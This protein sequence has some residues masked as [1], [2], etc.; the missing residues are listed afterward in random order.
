MISQVQPAPN[1]AVVLCTHN[2][3]QWIDEQIQSLL[4]QTHPVAIRVFDDA[5][6]DATVALVREYPEI[7]NIKCVVRSKS[8]GV[9]ENFSRGI[10]SVLD[11]G[12]TYIALA[13]QDDIWLPERIETGLAALQEAEEDTPAFS[14]HLVHSDLAMVNA[15]NQLIHK[16]FM[17][18]RQYQ[19]KPTNSL[20]TILG[21]NGVMGNTILM[22]H[23]LASLALPFPNNLHVHDYWLAL[24]AE[25]LGDRHY[26]DQALVRY[27]I[28]DKNVS[29]SA[30]TVTFGPKRWF[31]GLSFHGL[32]QRDFKL[33]FKED[34]RQNAVRLLLK[35]ERFN[36]LCADDQATITAFLNYLNFQDSR[37]KILVSVLNNRFLRPGLRHRLRVY[38]SILTSQRY[39]SVKQSHH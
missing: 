30:N 3:A 7:Q 22:N 25:L 34:S 12:F 32:I 11:E 26:I 37:F 16:S 19:T 10:Q 39:E 13:D 1:V 9:V 36:D 5:S 4:S 33:P 29:N 38:V 15:N 6:T 27:R 24:V 14:P 21:Q 35:D 28:H 20:A 18:W 8:L 23:H 17:Q 2:G 31:R